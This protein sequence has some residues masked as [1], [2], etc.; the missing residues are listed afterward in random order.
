MPS[1]HLKV[2]GVI[3]FHHQN[4]FAK[5]MTG[6]NQQKDPCFL[7]IIGKT[8]PPEFGGLRRCFQL[9]VLCFFVCF[10]GWGGVGGSTHLNEKQY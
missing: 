7:S 3:S 10:F 8:A 9:G 4:G 6:L 1:F 5:I 2:K